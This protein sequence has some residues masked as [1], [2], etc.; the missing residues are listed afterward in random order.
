MTTQE[1]TTHM[2]STTRIV[3]PAVPAEV[4]AYEASCQDRQ[5]IWRDAVWLATVD[6]TTLG[7]GD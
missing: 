4:L 7:E 2:P 6:D 5:P 3:A 1:S